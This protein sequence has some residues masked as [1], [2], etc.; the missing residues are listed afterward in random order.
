MPFVARDEA[1]KITA[2]S[3]EQ[4]PGMLE[5]LPYESP[6]LRA[7]Y[8]VL[9][10]DGDDHQKFEE[11]YASDFRLIRVIE[12]LIDALVRK[13]VL[14]VTDL[15]QAVQEKLVERRSLRD[16]INSLKLFGDDD[17]GVL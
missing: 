17:Q 15:P 5:E 13:N 8:S 16:N 2:L 7:F 1:G 4:R 12:D 6:E 10:G 3:L 14:C 9:G 11:L